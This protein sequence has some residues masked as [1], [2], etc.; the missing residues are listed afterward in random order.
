MKRSEKKRKKWIKPR[1][2]IVQHLVY[3]FIYLYCKVKYHI[4]IEKF[5]GKDSGPYLVLYNHQTGF[6]Q[7]FVG[8]P[9]KLPVYYV[10]SEDIFSLGFVSKILKYLVEPIPIKKQT[11]DVSAVLNCM[12][13]AKEGGTIA[14]SP[15][16]NRTYSGRTGYMK[17]AI[18]GLIKAL[19]MPVAFVRIEG[20]YG[21]HP[22]WSDKVRRG[23][24]RVYVSSV[25]DRDTY[26][27]MSDDE[28]YAHVTRELY[29]DEARVTGE[30]RSKHLAEGLERAIYVC[31]SHGLSEF[32]TCGDVIKC[33]RCGRSARYLP[34][35]ELSGIDGDFPFRFVADWYDYQSRFVNSLDPRGF[36][37]KALYTERVRLSEVMLYKSKKVIEKNAELNLYGDK[38]ILSGASIGKQLFVFDDVSAITV[39][40]KNKLNLYI[41]NTVYQIKGEKSFCALKYVNLFHRYKNVT[42]TVENGEFLGI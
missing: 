24:M 31:E 40:G 5:D 19:K 15:E 34:T 27:A 41:K 17:P 38:I 7:F 9:F 28:L 29:V 39:L 6:D 14:V 33:K 3:P 42:T 26:S 20:G 18:V 36:T 37:D 21:V 13:V 10:A 16:G 35:K 8:M 12:R 2:K 30:F 23:K 11:S 32:E 1:H 4:T 25:L 22:R